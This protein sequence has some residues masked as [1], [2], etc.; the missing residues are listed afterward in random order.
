M[1]LATL[2]PSMAWLRASVGSTDRML[3][4][5]SGSGW[6]P[7]SPAP[8]PRPGQQVVLR[9]VSNGSAQS[10]APLDNDSLELPQLRAAAPDG[11][12]R[13]PVAAAAAPP[14][15]Q[16][17]ALRPTPFRALADDHSDVETAGMWRTDELRPT[18]SRALADDHSDPDTGACQIPSHIV[19]HQDSEASTCGFQVAACRY[20]L[21]AASLVIR[22]CAGTLTPVQ[23]VTRANCSAETACACAPSC[24]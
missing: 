19:V 20:L 7:E 18:P 1:L 13:S 5:C 4:S 22:A 8:L 16:L 3:R 6:R 11:G 24:P 21:H 23:T 14:R 17:V 15:H 2:P 10:T 9:S 12:S